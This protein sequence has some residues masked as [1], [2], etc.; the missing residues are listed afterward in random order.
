M[1]GFAL[2]L[3]AG[4]PSLL[5]VD[6]RITATPSYVSPSTP[7]GAPVMANVTSAPSIPAG[8][9]EIGAASD[10]ATETGA[11]ALKPSDLSG[12]TQFISQVTDK[13]SAEFGRY[14]APG[15]F[16]TLFGP[17][18]GAITAVTTQLEASGLQVTGVA[19][20]GL[21][22]YFKGSA[23]SAESAF[24]TRIATYRL[25]NGTTGQATTSAIKLPSAIA[26][27]VT[28]VVGLDNLVAAKP[29]GGGALRQPVSDKGQ[30][31]QVPTAAL[32]HQTGA[33]SACS[34][35]Q[36]DAASFGGLSDDQI[37]NAYGAFGLYANRDFGG[38]QSI[39]VYE[40][41]PFQTSDIN[42]F[43]SCY[44]GTTEAG[45]MAGRLSVTPIDGGLPAGP[46]SGESVLDVEDVSAIAPG[47]NIDVYEAPNTSFGGLDEYSAIVND[48]TA[49]VVTSSWGLCEQA[50]QLGEPGL[51]QAENSL[52][53]QAAAQGQSVFAAAGDTGS[54]SCNAYRPPYPAS[55]QNPLS[56]LDPASQPYVISVG[57]TTIT[58]AS[59][60]PAQEQV[61]N[62][63]ANWGAGGGGISMS[64]TAPSWQQSAQVPGIPTL[65][66]ADYTQANS[67]EAASSYPTGFCDATG[68]GS[69]PGGPDP[70]GSLPCRTLPDVSAQADEFTGAVTVYSSS[71]V[72][73]G[74]PDGWITIGGTSSATPIWAAALTL[75]N[76][77]G[78]GACTSSG[79]GV[80]FASPL[81]YGLAS[82]PTAYQASFNDITSGNDDIYGL[83]NG[84][85]F[86]ATT[87][88]DLASGLGSPRL[89]GAGGV[90]GLAY[91]LCDYATP[92]GGQPTV[93]SLNPSFLSTA[94]G[95]VVLDG[96]GFE[97]AGTADVASIEVGAGQIA[98]ASM[99]V[100]SSTSITA[101]FPP[102]TATLA[103]NSP[104]PQDGAGPADVIVTLSDGQ[105]S[106][107]GPAAT[108]EYVDESSSQSIPSVTGV[109]SYGGSE[110]APVP[111]TIFGSG[112]SSGGPTR[113]T[114]VLFG[115]V[116]ATSFAVE[117]P[118]EILV[119]PPAYSTQA[120]SPGLPSGENASN[121]IC[122]V[123]V[124]VGN[125]NG[126]SAE[127]IILPPY[128][129]Y[130]LQATAM[131][132]AALPPGCGC[133]YEP[134]PSE[135]D[136]I[137]Q[138]TITAVSTTT[139]D[140]G[141]LAD[142]LGGSLITFAGTGFNPL[143]T[144]WVDIGAPGL[145]SSI[146]YNVAYESGTVIEIEAPPIAASAA[147]AT[148][149]PASVPLSINTLA[150]QSAAGPAVVYAGIPTV[151]SVVN[152]SNDT[153][154]GGLS[155]AA[156]TGG[157][158]ITISGAGFEQAVGPLGFVDIATPY[159]LGTQY[160]YTVASDTSISTETVAQNPAIVDTEVCTVT[161]CSLNPPADYFVLFP[162]GNPNVDSISP[163]S[164][165]PAGG[166]SVTIGGENLGCVTGVFF[167]SVTAATFSN[168]QAILDC[169]SSNLVS[170]ISPPGG[171]GTTVP[172]TVT[173]L[174]SEFTGF[175]PST[176]TASFTYVASA[177]TALPPTRLL[178][179]RTNSGALGPNSSLNLTVTG[180]SVPSDATAVALNVTVTGSSSASDLTVYPTGEAQPATSNLNWVAG[181]TVPNLVIVPVGTNGQ[182]TF[183]NALGQ[184]NVLADLEGYFAPE[185][186]GST[187]GSYVPLAPARITDTRSDSGYPNAGRPLPAG[188]TI[189]VQV[190]GAGLV[191]ASGVTAA[192]LNVTVT[193]TTSASDLTIYPKGESE[194]DTSNLNWVAGDTVANRVV[195]PV[196]A[197]G[198][199]SIS[200]DLG[201][202]DVIVDVNGYFTDG[203]STPSNASLYTP[204]TPT[205]LVDTRTTGGTLG[206]GGT[207]IAQIGGSGGI[208]LS[209]TA[210]V[211]NVTA[212]NTTAA[213]DFTVYP[214]GTRPGTS[215]LNWQTGQT[216]P[217]LTVA[218][219]SETGAIAVY[220]V[221]GSADLIIDAFGYFSPIETP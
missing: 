13:H 95:S 49:K 138:P 197:G 102:A 116:A 34:N 20:D 148:V 16:K 207:Y 220:N 2:P 144:S 104:G 100:T 190:T 58:N 14:L 7:S 118:F 77:S 155:G 70:G 188:G 96:T 76:A 105:S 17:A 159:S 206:A 121:D 136:Y 211:L 94:G 156:D 135:F 108:M 215:D 151:N 131:G 10:S 181:E 202:T 115:G 117:S 218:T 75:V 129:G 114:T 69:D 51:Q 122:Q 103:G 152:N 120:C 182:V 119:T 124:Q 128:E 40:L 166:T 172:V 52:F 178:D 184:T 113:T 157:T 169:G 74:T 210:A 176:T 200:N 28:S 45:Q 8:A 183:Y 192:L 26:S 87:G 88:Y 80:G 145:E 212:T 63:G 203:S 191:P 60:T 36:S 85:V 141:S 47:A 25:A 11:V 219:L 214:G 98:A 133:E 149:Q 79:T 23:V 32:P 61:W 168:A 29:Q 101:I 99:T 5:T 189:N 89:T 57:G 137:P 134:A 161:G 193:N 56:V 170:A 9:A 158:P 90:P 139:T 146:D 106:A 93:S 109:S 163:S 217:N 186:S 221:A 125:A 41:E 92:V 180:G 19:K 153:T 150:G 216:V 65:G 66:S 18:P 82:N 73:S 177:Y 208:G 162:P 198:E 62:D 147:G 213:S 64:W 1:A 12:L 42:T 140:P 24:D 201:T 4:G 86:P 50:V 195:V 27:A 179:T 132:V 81:L 143:T 160:T 54:D 67:V 112:F 6:A 84:Q 44:F 111:V 165:P 22:V 59:T 204:I 174:E 33:P 194:P 123:Q 48:D 31:K 196:G 167:G 30:E 199:I 142:E 91:Y 205:R 130:A 71:F 39:A 110:T 187:A 83:D 46:G 97:S 154:V 171:A 175:G 15:A 127:G 164:G 126:Q 68:S 107:P 53:E 55:G 78:T 35:A 209:A 21:L 38:G 185:T 43:D 37:A 72:S 3:L 173:T